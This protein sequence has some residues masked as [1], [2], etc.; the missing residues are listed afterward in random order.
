MSCLSHR[1]ITADNKV[2]AN[3]QTCLIIIGWANI[4]KEVDLTNDGQYSKY[5]HA[6]LTMSTWK[7]YNHAKLQQIH[8]AISSEEGH[9]ASNIFV[10]AKP[11]GKIYLL[12]LIFAVMQ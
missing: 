11:I 9:Q 7:D 3:F 8:Q 6:D 1:P 4:A 12:T 10:S 2:S 5:G